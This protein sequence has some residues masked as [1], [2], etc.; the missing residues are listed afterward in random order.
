MRNHMMVALAAALGMACSDR[1]QMVDPPLLDASEGVEN[2]ADAAGREYEVTI[3]N[4]T[5]GQPLSPGVIATHT[6]QVS[7][8]AVGTGASEGVRLIAENGDPAT[9]SAELMATAGVDGVTATMAP[10]HRIGGPGSTSLTTT[11]AARA[12]ANRLSLVL[13]LICTNDGFVG[14]DGVELPRG[15][16]AETYYADAY[17]AGTEVNDELSENVVDACPAIGPVGG[18]ADGNGRVAE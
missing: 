8:F 7:Y 18:A 4:L 9:A 12:N 14:L 10:V 2:A 11:I 6:K 5:G 3:T 16:E 17:D 13:M 1:D 15:F